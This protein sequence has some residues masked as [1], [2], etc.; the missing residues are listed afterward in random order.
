MISCG[1]FR[2]KKTVQIS[3]I[4]DSGP[5]NAGLV[6]VHFKMAAHTSSFNK[7]LARA[8][9]KNAIVFADKGI[10]WTIIRRAL[11]CNANGGDYGKSNIAF[12]GTRILPEVFS[13]QL[14]FKSNC[15]GLRLS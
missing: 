14:I 15:P 1:Y 2:T 6:I 7:S 3:L 5:S 4:H 12:P 10:F 11:P 13:W 9:G 8:A